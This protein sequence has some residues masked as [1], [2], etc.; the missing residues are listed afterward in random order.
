MTGIIKTLMAMNPTERSTL[1]SVLTANPRNAL[2]LKEAHSEALS[3]SKVISYAFLKDL[4]EAQKEERAEASRNN[5]PADAVRHGYWSALLSSK[6]S[7]NDAM[8]VVFAHEADQIRSEDPLVKLASTMDLHN[9]QVGLDIG[10]LAKGAA[11]EV[12]REAVLKALFEG[13]LRFIEPKTGKL[14]PTKSLQP[15]S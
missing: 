7:Y 4:P 11:N 8:R 2:V 12:L 10:A 13:R 6:L 1:W 5:G 9:N 3:W 15:S 14:V